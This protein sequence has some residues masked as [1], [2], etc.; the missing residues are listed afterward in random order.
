LEGVV[1]VVGIVAAVPVGRGEDVLPFD[2]A[3]FF[4]LELV[5]VVLYGLVL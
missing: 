2:A 4:Y 5:D 1:L 3:L